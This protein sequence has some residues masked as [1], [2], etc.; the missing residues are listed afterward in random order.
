MN[1]MLPSSEI[2]EAEKRAYTEADVHAKL[3]EPDMTALGYP[4]RTSGQADGEHFLEQRRLAVRRLKTGHR[5]GFYDGL[6]LIGNSPIVLCEL[7]RYDELDSDTALEA[8]I[9][10][11]QGYARSD[12]F[13][14]P[15][16][17]LLLYC[18]KPSR[19]RFFRLRP[20]G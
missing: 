15:P 11:L 9:R 2:P 18:G 12:D 7:K 20:D 19:T 14:R 8:A 3:F 4:P 5:R 16:P 1:P 17:F 10:Q 13:G 6:Y